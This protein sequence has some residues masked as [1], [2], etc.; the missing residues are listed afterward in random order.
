MTAIDEF[1]NKFTT[2]K[3]TLYYLIGLVSLAYFFS[4]FNLV[5]FNPLDISISVAI[6]LAVGITINAIFAG[7]LGAR[8]KIESV[9]ITLLILALIFP[10]KFP[11]DIWFA[12]LATTLAIA[13]KYLLT[14][15]KHHIFNPVAVAAVGMALLY[16]NNG[17]TW[18]IGTPIM[19]P[20]VLIGGLL[21]ARRLRA[22]KLIIAF[23]T[24]Y[25]VVTAIGAI[26]NGG[27][28][29][30]IWT[31]WQMNF[32]HS[33]L[34]FFAFVML[35]EPLTSPNKTKAIYFAI[36]VALLYSTIQLH[37]SWIALTPEVALCLGNIFAHIVRPRRVIA[38]PIVTEAPTS[39]VLQIN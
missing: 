26:L 36:I 10:V 22:G 30:D 19:M 15:E 18:W 12:V 38:P 21:L 14:V 4:F 8:S 39:T 17:A 31:S 3:L 37:L 25:L 2:Y 33:A 16:P 35:T 29:T 13:S 34:I 23:F 6:I 32:T 7:I 24:T 28:L 1:L 27:V 5:T 20:F 11:A 9:A